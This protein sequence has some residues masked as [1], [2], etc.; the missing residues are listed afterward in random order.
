MFYFESPNLPFVLTDFGCSCMMLEGGEVAS[1]G[2]REAPVE[3][4]L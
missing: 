1:V 4:S 3:C 2:P